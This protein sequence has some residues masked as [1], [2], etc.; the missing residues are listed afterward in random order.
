MGGGVGADVDAVGAA[1]QLVGQRDDSGCVPAVVV[2]QSTAQLEMGSH[3]SLAMS[4]EKG[5]RINENCWDGMGWMDGRIT[6]Q[7]SST[8]TC[9]H[10]ELAHSPSSL[11][12]STAKCDSWTRAS[13]GNIENIPY[14]DAAGQIQIPPCNIIPTTHVYLLT[15]DHHACHSCP[16]SALLDDNPWIQQRERI[17]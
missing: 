1:E 3:R 2:D 11:T 16:F 17:Q 7:S 8:Q 15:F 10:A 12:L 6:H 14:N 13:M 9:S 5:T 4:W